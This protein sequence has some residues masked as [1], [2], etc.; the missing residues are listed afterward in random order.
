MQSIRQCFSYLGLPTVPNCPLSGLNRLLI[1]S[2]AS[3]V[4]W[5]VESRP[6]WCFYTFKMY[7]NVLVE[8][9]AF[10]WYFTAERKL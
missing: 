5:T 6:C 8:G 1:E 9:W 3:G 2:H 10:H 7:F 4:F